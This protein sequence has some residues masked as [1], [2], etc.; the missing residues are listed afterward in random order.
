MNKKIKL[1]I[2]KSISRFG[3]HVIRVRKAPRRE[4]SSKHNDESIKLLV[5]LGA[6]D[7]FH[8]DWINV[9]MPNQFYSFGQTNISITHDFTSLKPL[10]FKNQSVDIF[11]CSHVVE[12]LS[13]EV[14]QHLLREISRCLKQSGTLRITCPDMALQYSAF[15]RGDID[16]WCDLDPWNLG[17]ET[18]EFKLLENFTTLLCV[19]SKFPARIVE[20]EMVEAVY[21]THDM[22]SFF[23]HF[24]NLLPP[25]A[26]EIFPEGHINWF[27]HE[28]LG[29]MLYE[30]G[31]QNWE[32]SAFLQSRRWEMRDPRLF[33]N[34]CPELSLYIEGTK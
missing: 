26:N 31:I 4:R 15:G 10:P 25:N 33:D 8:H 20:K 2:R 30:A 23:D 27:T 7:F 24:L 32:R 17:N 16:F 3:I 5:N 14:V 9:D 19:Q 28:K 11:Y 34:T 6:G 21:H 18:I 12:H 29:G 13:N 22:H 1:F